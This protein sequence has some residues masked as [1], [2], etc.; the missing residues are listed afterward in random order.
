MSS[1]ISEHCLAGQRMGLMQ[2][3]GFLA[4]SVFLQ[5]SQGPS[6]NR[7]RT[8][9]H[10]NQWELSS[11]S[12]QIRAWGS[13]S[14]SISTKYTERGKG[15]HLQEYDHSSGLVASVSRS[16]IKAIKNRSA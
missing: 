5:H 11:P 3:P 9:W 6:E 2:P 4:G 10:W 1:V 16:Q 7:G 13:Q 12:K 14:T 15:N 8:P